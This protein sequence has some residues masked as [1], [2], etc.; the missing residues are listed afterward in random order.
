MEGSDGGR[1]KKEGRE[2]RGATRKAGSPGLGVMKKEKEEKGLKEGAN[3][4]HERQQ[5]ISAHLA[6]QNTVHL[7]L[8]QK[9]GWETLAVGKRQVWGKGGRRVPDKKGEEG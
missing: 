5:S 7:A 3:N 1:W 4:W 2:G 6:D 8:F 9:R